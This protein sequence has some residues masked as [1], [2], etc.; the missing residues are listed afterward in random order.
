MTYGTTYA[1]ESVN[2]TYGI[3]HILSGIQYESLNVSW[4]DRTAHTAGTTYYYCVVARSSTASTVAE[5][6]G[7]NAYC[8]IVLE[9]LN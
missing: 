8:E 6:L 1:T 3:H 9:E 7:N 4:I 5:N 2:A